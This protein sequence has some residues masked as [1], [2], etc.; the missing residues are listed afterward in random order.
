MF[1][2]GKILYTDIFDSQHWTTFCYDFDP[3]TGE[4]TAY[5]QYNGE[6]DSEP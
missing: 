1:A 5:H 3:A 4:F 2:Y 6:N